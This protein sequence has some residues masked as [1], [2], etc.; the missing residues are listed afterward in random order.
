MD[1]E[2]ELQKLLAV[3]IE[4]VGILTEKSNWWTA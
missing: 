4:K 2:E 1:L 3:V